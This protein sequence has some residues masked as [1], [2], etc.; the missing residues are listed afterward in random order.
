MIFSDT[1][2]AG[3]K[4]PL[5][6][7]SIASQDKRENILDKLSKLEASTTLSLNKGKRPIF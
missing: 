5:D 3:F 1:I 2:V 4:T 7:A 6:T